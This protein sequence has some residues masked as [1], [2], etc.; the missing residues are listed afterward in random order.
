MGMI[1]ELA[2]VLGAD[3]RLRFEIQ[4]TRDGKLVIVVQPYFGSPVE[5]LGEDES[6]LRAALAM[7]LRVSG[8]VQALDTDFPRLLLEYASRRSEVAD[9]ITALDALKEAAKAGARIQNEQRESGSDKPQKV[10]KP[11]KQPEP[12][13]SAP[14]PSVAQ[15][16]ALPSN[17]NSLF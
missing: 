12:I 15:P 11:E 6:P 16:I 17:P 10:G 9:Q 14:A 4:R 2:D 5:N 7:P 1:E 8:T 3:E 13:P